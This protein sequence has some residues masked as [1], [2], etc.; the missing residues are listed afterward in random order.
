MGPTV[1]LIDGCTYLPSVRTL[2]IHRTSPRLLF[3]G[4]DDATV[5]AWDFHHNRS[6]SETVEYE[7]HAHH[8]ALAVQPLASAF[9]PWRAMDFHAASDSLVVGSDAQSLLLVRYASRAHHAIA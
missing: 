4:S 2:A 7:K 8:K 1:R 3:S 5:L 9:L 6:A